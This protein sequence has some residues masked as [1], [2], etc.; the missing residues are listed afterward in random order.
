[1]IFLFASLLALGVFLIFAAIAGM[2]R[3]SN[4]MDM[5][6]R[7][8]AEPK[9][10]EDIEMSR[11]FT[12]RVIEPLIRGIARTLARLTPQYFAESTRRRLEVAGNPYNWTVAELLGLRMLAALLGATFFAF[13][14]AALGVNPAGIVLLS[15]AGLG[16]GFYLPIFWLGLKARSRQQE[17]QRTLPDA[18]D[19]LT[20]CVEAGLGFDAALAKLSEK[21]DNEISR[22]FGRS[23]IEMR[24]G[25]ARQAA[26]RDM[27]NR[28]GVQDV[29]SFVGA[30][31][32]A[33]QLGT[34]IAQ[35]LRIQSDQMRVLRR[36]RAQEAA[37]QTPVKI[38]FPLVFF[39]FPSLFAVI[40]GPAVIR[41]ISQGLFK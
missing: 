23:L 41:L 20:I 13:V 34:P 8:Y 35:V 27:A 17:I 7:Q 26:L 18:L 12:T 21:W 6:V 33:D 5:L 11:P 36:Q 14:F 31:I 2:F 37:N 10:L 15:V 25:K 22:A 28:T 3:E 32:Q 39:I 29:V 24:L 40:L 16:L 1:M 19:L 9:M 4:R 30:M 38:V